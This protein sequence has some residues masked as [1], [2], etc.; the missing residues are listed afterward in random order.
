MVKSMSKTLKSVFLLLSFFLTSVSFAGMQ[1][2]EMAD[3][4]RAE[5][6]I[7]IVVAVILIILAGLFAYLILSDNRLKKLE[8]EIDSEINKASNS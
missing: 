8:Q 2:V 5:G 3:Q 6:K 1:E 4:F 7:Y